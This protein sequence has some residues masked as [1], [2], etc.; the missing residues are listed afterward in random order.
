M[1]P[2]PNFQL[3]S[4]CFITIISKQIFEAIPTWICIFC[5]HVGKKFRERLQENNIHT[6]ETFFTTNRLELCRPWRRTWDKLF[7]FNTNTLRLFAFSLY[8]RVC[9][10]KSLVKQHIIWLRPNCENIRVSVLSTPLSY[11]NNNN[12]IIRLFLLLSS[13]DIA[14]VI[15]A[16]S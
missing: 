13:D 14:V 1:T 3:D 10:H 9:V 16:Y 11:R 12:N 5:L 2:M 8:I 15:W 6:L 4:V 7:L